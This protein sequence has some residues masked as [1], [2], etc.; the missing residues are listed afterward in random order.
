MRL[1]FT[2]QRKP[3]MRRAKLFVTTATVIFGSIVVAGL[4]LGI[5]PN[6]TASIAPGFYRTT[7]DVNTLLIAFCPSGDAER[8][9]IM[10]GYR[11]RGMQ[12]PDHYAAIL[13][14]IAARAGDIVTVTK[15]GIGL[16]GGPLLP[17]TQQF[18]KDSQ[19]HSMHPW[20]Q[21]T[22]HVAPGT[23][24]VVSTYCKYSYDSRYYGPIKL[25]DV[26]AHV[27]PLWTF[28]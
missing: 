3:N 8:E 13:K 24:W 2:L 7:R 5:R 21:G 6:F 25:T 16:N 22:Y 12:C 1:P 19:K 4:V 11:P 9:S 18:E 23:I 15:Q 27:K 17:N 26:I 10:R 14:P 28:K 20:P